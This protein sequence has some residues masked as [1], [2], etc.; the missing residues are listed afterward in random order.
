MFDNLIEHGDKL[1]EE[2]KIE[3]AKNIF[4]T[5]N[6]E[7]PGDKKIL[8]NL[9]VIEYCKN[10]IESAKEYFEKALK[11]DPGYEIAKENLE[12]LMNETMVNN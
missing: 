6:N 9:G 4:Y 7:Y 1:L 12:M 2:N 5:L 10:N 8:T 3:E 11:I